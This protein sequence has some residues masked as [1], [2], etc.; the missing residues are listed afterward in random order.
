[1]RS[2]AKDFV[3]TDPIIAMVLAAH[4][5]AA[6]IHRV[7]FGGHRVEGRAGRV[8]DFEEQVVTPAILEAH[9]LG[10]I[11]DLVHLAIK[12]L[13]VGGTSIGTDSISAC[14]KAPPV[15]FSKVVAALGPR[16]MAG[17]KPA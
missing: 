15:R 5:A 14:V 2:I 9:A 17:A 8:F 10:Q 11:A 16:I 13:L 7:A 12:L 4:V 3:S 6:A 1:M